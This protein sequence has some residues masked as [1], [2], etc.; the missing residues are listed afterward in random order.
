[1][2]HDERVAN[3]EPLTLRFCHILLSQNFTY[4][5]SGELDQS[6]WAGRGL[7]YSFQFVFGLSRSDISLE[8]A[9]KRVADFRIEFGDHVV[10]GLVGNNAETF[11]SRSCD[12]HLSYLPFTGAWSV[13]ADWQQASG[14][15]CD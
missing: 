6:R 8:F 15:G 13:A 10:E 7:D 14:S 9:H 3:D 11:D 12:G 2:F 5:E 1:L 4:V